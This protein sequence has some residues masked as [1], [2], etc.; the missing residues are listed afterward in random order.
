MTLWGF[1]FMHLI[2]QMWP[3]FLQNWIV[4]ELQKDL[5]INTYSWL[6]GEVMPISC[7]W[8]GIIGMSLGIGVT[9]PKNWNHFSFVRA[10]FNFTNMI[11][12][13]VKSTP[14]LDQ[15]LVPSNCKSS[16]ICSCWIQQVL[17]L[18][19]QAMSVTSFRVVVVLRS[20]KFHHWPPSN[21][22]TQGI[23]EGRN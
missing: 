9:I 11:S 3:I 17:V 8:R 1:G 23:H 20:V 10:L 5:M 6:T 16:F 13:N 18:T 7:L 4:R 22:E 12:I 21:N 19:A 2:N 14:T 15:G